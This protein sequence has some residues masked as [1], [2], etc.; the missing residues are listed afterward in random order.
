ML[1]M[2][3]FE[4]VANGSEINLHAESNDIE[5]SVRAARDT[6]ELQGVST[7]PDK[8][9]S[10]VFEDDFES[11][12]SFKSWLVYNSLG[13]GGHGLR[14]PEAVFIDEGVLNISAFEDDGRIIS[15][16]LRL[17]GFNQTFGKYIARVR[18]SV[19]A[20]ATTSGV[21]LTWPVSQNNKRDGE[22]DF[23][24]TLHLPHDRSHF[25][26]FVHKMSAPHGIAAKIEH[27]F[28]ASKW[29]IVGMEWTKEKVSFWVNGELASEYKNGQNIPN[30]SHSKHYLAIQLDPKRSNSL[31]S[32][33]VL[34]QV[35]WVKQ[36]KLIE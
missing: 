29:N 16:G 11:S 6:K 27:D 17:I 32:E 26:S 1:T 15:G 30:K 34:M 8:R 23:Y 20:T 10:L 25:Y 3:V 13:H 5:T 7:D 14:L 36:Y 21:V 24:E 12:A 35:D 18:T 31:G 19:D 22:L 2:I 9:W 28:S 4:Q 33:K